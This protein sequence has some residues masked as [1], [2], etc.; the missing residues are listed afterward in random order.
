VQHH[1]PPGLHPACV[2]VQEDRLL[3]EGS[4]AR[5]LFW[6]AHLRKT[7]S[8]VLLQYLAEE[9]FLTLQLLFTGSLAGSVLTQQLGLLLTNPLARSD[10]QQPGMGSD[11]DGH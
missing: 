2:S 4:I 1:C 3:L 7:L 5:S 9:A 6:R 11:R 8:P 10:W